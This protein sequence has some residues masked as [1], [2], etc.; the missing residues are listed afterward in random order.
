MLVCSVVYTTIILLHVAVIYA[1]ITCKLLLILFYMHD[2][3]CV[4]SK[5]VLLDQLFM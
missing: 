1:M 3:L 5:S 2:V 4:Y